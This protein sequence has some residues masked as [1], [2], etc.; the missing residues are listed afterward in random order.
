MFGGVESDANHTRLA[1]PRHADYG[2]PIPN[3]TTLKTALVDP[4][5]PSSLG[6]RARA[7]RWDV[8]LTQFPDL[9]GMRVLDLGGQTSF[10]A[11]APVRP[12]H[13]TLVDPNI[14]HLQD[15]AK[16][17]AVIQGDACDHSLNLTGY[18]LCF[19]NSTIEHVGGP[20]R[21]A[22]FAH[23]VLTAAPQHWIQTP[24]RYFPLEPHW[25]FP[26]F[27]FLPLC[28]K[29][30]L[31]E[32]WTLGQPKGGGPV[33]AA[34]DIELLTATEMKHLFPKSVL[35]RERVAGL[36][37]SLVVIQMAGSPLAPKPP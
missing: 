30:W 18:D 6:A 4:K 19:S 22:Q 28:A 1:Q 35:W 16:W 8:M 25:L 34:L 37:K 14:A 21:R 20:Y 17:M 7:K 24:Y 15:R 12:E 33:G 31:G 36:V 5:S 27:Q 9:A 32:R 29:A 23:T 11:T 2:G 26:G 3:A 10:W 13:V